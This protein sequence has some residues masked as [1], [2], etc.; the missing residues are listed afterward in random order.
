MEAI[1][2]IQARDVSKSYGEKV[3]F[4][5]IS[6]SISQG[7]KVALI[8]PNGSGKTTLLNILA[9]L[10]Y[11]DEGFCTCRT[12]L[13]ISYLPQNPAFNETLSVDEVLLSADNEQTRLIRAYEEF[14]SDP[15]NARDPAKAKELQ[16]LI[17]RMDALQAW[18]YE[19]RV[20]Q[21]LTMLK[22]GKLTAPVQSLSGGQV[23]RL[24][25]ARVLIEEPDFLLLD[26]PTN[27]LDIEMIEWLEGFFSR[28]KVTLLM[29]THDRYFLDAV[30]NEIIEMENSQVFTYKG[31]YASFLEKKH[32]RKAAE[33]ARNEKAI[34]LLRK[35]TEWMRR[36]PP[37]RTSKSKARIASYQTLKEET[38]GIRQKGMGAIPVQMSRLGSKILELQNVCKTF[39][40]LNVLDNFSYVFKKGERIGI[41]GPN[42]TGKSTLLNIVTGNLRPD[43]GKVITG[44]TIQFGYFR[45]EGILVD[46]EKKVLE[47]ITDHAEQIQFGKGGS[48][49]AAQF[50][51]YFNFPNHMHHDRVAKL[52]GGE[53]RRLYLLT[54]LISNPNFLILDE[55]TNDL[56]IETLNLLEDYLLRFQGCLIIVSHDRYFLDRLADHLFVFR[57]IGD[58]KDFSSNYTA[59]RLQSNNTQKAAANKPKAE[60]PN[61]PSASKE[62]KKKLTYKEQKELELLEREIDTLE[63]EK[64]ALIEQM[65]SGALAQDK[66]LECSERYKAVENLLDVKSDRWLE[67]S[68]RS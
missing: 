4:R 59:Y 29:V 3:L 26:E 2:Y 63:Q 27:H 36:S 57:G 66:L 52:S 17:E 14:V 65:N 64:A 46:D 38:S 40:G 23:K 5:G 28:Q 30:C 34:N 12:G 37:A 8:A 31:N 22:I 15:D 45:Q 39:D 54:V 13:R 61:K 24:A 48:M 49:S 42:G 19:Q 58:I 60:K 32:E 51:R 67:L 62:E 68:D 44:E 1:N 11:P 6:V 41:V 18:D 47:V 33:A 50:L 7:Q 16:K 35:E 9:G 53:K 25:L 21:V 43:A 10:D 55:P 56:D 20:K